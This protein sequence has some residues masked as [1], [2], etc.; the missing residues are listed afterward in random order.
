MARAFRYL[1]RLPWLLVHLLLGLPVTL[2]LLMRPW[3]DW[4]WRGQRLDEAVVRWWSGGLLRVFGF[5]LRRIGQ[6]LDGGV[7]MVANHVSWVDIEMI[8]SQKLVGFVA[9]AE[10]AHWPLV[11]WMA[12]RGHTIFHQRGSNESLGG[13]M[14][15]MGARLRQARPVAVFPE[16]R[17]RD[18]HAVGPFH[19]RIFTAAVEAGV[20]VQP[21]AL[22]YGR[23]GAAQTVVAFGPKESFVANFV[24]LLGEPSRD[25]E[26]HFLEPIDCTAMEGRKQ[27]AELA[28]HRVVAAL[29]AR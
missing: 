1:Y 18:G 2:V 4:R 22:R 20:P 17:T 8:H 25:A 7:L 12:S 24:R 27:I 21:V 13:V 3:A 11:G 10:I 6:P 19:A 28:R 16:G 29:Q 23:D 14:D 9:K 15:E 26:V 5:R